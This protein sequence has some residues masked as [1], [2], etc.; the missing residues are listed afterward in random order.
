[1][2]TLLLYF[3]LLLSTL[4]SYAAPFLGAAPHFKPSPQ[5][6][7]L[8]FGCRTDHLSIYFLSTLEEVDGL[9]GGEPAFRP[10]Y[11]GPLSVGVLDV[12]LDRNYPTRACQG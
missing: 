11:R 10:V 12:Y 5:A 3:Y 2:P 1:M 8:G 9:A 4:E 7:A 6:R